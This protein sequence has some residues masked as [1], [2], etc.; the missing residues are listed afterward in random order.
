VYVSTRNGR[1]IEFFFPPEDPV[2]EPVMAFLVPSRGPA[3]PRKTV[4]EKTNGASAS[5]SPYG[6]TLK[7]LGFLPDRDKLVYYS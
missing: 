4:I 6:E 7:T 3:S 1:E 5:R 2:A